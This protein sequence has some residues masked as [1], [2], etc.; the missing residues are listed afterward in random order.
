MKNSNFFTFLR[1]TFALRSGSRDPIESGS[2]PDPDTDTQ[3]WNLPCG[4]DSTTWARY[5]RIHLIFSCWPSPRFAFTRQLKKIK[6]Q[7]WKQWSKFGR[8]PLV[9]VRRSVKK[10]RM[11]SYLRWTVKSTWMQNRQGTINKQ[12]G[13]HLKILFKTPSKNMYATL[14]RYIT[15][16]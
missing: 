10:F 7:A 5:A 2:K 3:H 9:W 1:V 6:G 12:W 15:M 13:Q 11:L 14:I 8:G 16:N 4:M